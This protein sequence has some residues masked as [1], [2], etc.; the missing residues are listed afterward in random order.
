MS[1]SKDTLSPDALDR[2]LLALLRKDARMPIARLSKS[3]GVSR[4]TVYGRIQKLQQA[5]VI[6][7]FT[8]L[9]NRE[10]DRQQIR[11]HVLIKVIGK[12]T[13]TTEKQLHGIAQIVALHAIS[14]AYDLI[15]VLEAANAAELNELIDRIGELEGVEMT[16]SSIVLATKWSRRDPVS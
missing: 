8:V 1:S 5:G 7:G 10:I 11:A 4:A 15:A 3:L 16:T 6:E 14:G 2:R 13:R 12:L 9:V